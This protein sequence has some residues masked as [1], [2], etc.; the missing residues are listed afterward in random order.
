MT[1]T[2]TSGSSL[3][4]TVTTASSPTVLI[5]RRFTSVRTMKK[6]DAS[7]TRWPESPGTMLARPAAAASATAGLPTQLEHQVTQV[8]MKPVPRPSSFST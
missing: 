7:R 2:A 1:T 3:I 8:T 4:R 5:P 6:A